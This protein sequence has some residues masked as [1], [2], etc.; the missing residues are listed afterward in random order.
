MVEKIRDTYA[1]AK[2]AANANGN[3]NQDLLNDIENEFINNM[4]NMCRLQAP[5]ILVQVLPGI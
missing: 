2:L 5:G 1:H 4:R 3:G